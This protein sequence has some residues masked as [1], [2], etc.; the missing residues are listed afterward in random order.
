[1]SPGAPEAKGR[2][3]KAEEDPERGDDALSV[4]GR[5]RP[6]RR[7]GRRGLVISSCRVTHRSAPAL[8]MP[9]DPFPERV[10]IESRERPEWWRRGESNP[11]PRRC[12]RRALPT[13]LRPRFPVPRVRR[14]RANPPSDR[15]IVLGRGP[16][17]KRPTARA[18]E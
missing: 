2:L 3:G 18:S 1:R 15:I 6:A 8:A 12:E 10:T 13:E 14:N 17:D 16:A 11:R 7:L 5:R 9:G 4:A